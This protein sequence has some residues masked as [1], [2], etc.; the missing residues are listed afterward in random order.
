M[1]FD[2]RFALGTGSRRWPAAAASLVLAI[3][4]VLLILFLFLQNWRATVVPSLA[5]PISLIATFGLLFFNG[6]TLNQMSFGGLALG[7]GL[8]TPALFA[9]LSGL[10][11]RRLASLAGAA[12]LAAWAV[13][14]LAGWI[15]HVRQRTDLHGKARV[16]G[17]ADAH[18]APRHPGGPAVRTG[19]GHRC[20][21]VA[22][23]RRRRQRR[24]DGPR[25]ARAG[26]SREQR[27]A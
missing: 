20:T 22:R 21:R 25:R 12:V 27:Q 18:G 19:R 5:I 24:H 13:A 10:P 2:L 15:G 1:N 6:F 4:L 14:L 8:I 3:V 23:A 7:I 11:R 17:A 16:R 9:L 26:R